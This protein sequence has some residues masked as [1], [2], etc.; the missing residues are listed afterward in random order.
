M[1]PLPF[2]QPTFV[3]S[4]LLLFL[5]FPA[6]SAPAADALCPRSA[7]T[8]KRVQRT[9]TEE[10]L[11]QL[12]PDGTRDAES[13][14]ISIDLTRTKNMLIPELKRRGL[15]PDE[16]LIEVD[17]GERL[18]PV[19][20]DRDR[21]TISGGPANRQTDFRVVFKRKHK[22]IH[23]TEARLFESLKYPVVAKEDYAAYPVPELSLPDD[24]V[25][26]SGIDPGLVR[27]SAQLQ[28]ENINWT[29][30]SKASPSL[31]KAFAEHG[32]ALKLSLSFGPDAVPTSIR[33]LDTVSKKEI[34]ADLDEIYITGG[35][36]FSWHFFDWDSEFVKR[37]LRFFDSWLPEK[38][39]QFKREVQL[40]TKT[41]AQPRELRANLSAYQRPMNIKLGETTPNREYYNPPLA[42]W[43]ERQ[44]VRWDPKKA[45]TTLPEMI[46]SLQQQRAWF[47]KN[48]SVCDE[49][50]KTLGFRWTNL[51]SGRDNAARELDNG[52][53]GVDLMSYYKMMLD[54]EREFH[55]MLGNWKAAEQLAKIADGIRTTLNER[56]WSEDLALYVDLIPSEQGNWKRDTNLSATGFWPAM[57]HVPDR[58]KLERMISE[59]LRNPKRFGSPFFPPSTSI[60][61]PHYDPSGDYWRGG[62]WPPDFIFFGDFLFENGLRKEASELL[63]KILATYTTVSR[64]YQKGESPQ[65]LI[66][67][68][69]SESEAAEMK[70]RGT[71]FEFYGLKKIDDRVAPTFGRKIREDGSYHQTRK[72]F[73]GWG[74]ATP[75]ESLRFIVG[76]DAVPAYAGPKKD[77]NRWIWTLLT[78]PQFNYHQIKAN[79]VLRP[80]AE[81]VAR[82]KSSFQGF[83]KLLKKAELAPVREELDK[84]GKG[85][86]EFSP[87]FNPEGQTELKHI[88]FDNT[89]ID[90]KV[91]RLESDR[92]IRLTVKSKERIRLQF[93]QNWSASGATDTPEASSSIVEIGSDRPVV[94]LTLA[95]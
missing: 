80:I 35:A 2:L 5:I 88:L 75:L 50:G 9:P 71:V 58:T 76:L 51:G 56:Y 66:Y 4:S 43:S 85:Y 82:P 38:M 11:H 81:Y 65:Q 18:I 72:N 36:A 70:R 95:R 46:L 89:W 45:S 74:S 61:N 55:L 22:E 23:V 49:N 39:R 93:N 34:P 33:V 91:E 83:E 57:A 21:L 6:Y 8:V 20:M 37:Y 44:V 60:D 78:D 16:I 40:K 12:V 30:T 25:R 54:Q 64:A 63:Q 73:A 92:H 77:I 79:P 1:R 29:L 3:A 27:L 48:H 24:F 67:G 47:L 62:G 7:A 13:G 10:A 31:K 19:S 94:E 84:L 87:T 59:N 15:T 42:G 14:E 52:G 68:K 53:L 41:G 28:R 32:S 86:L 26:K 17:G 90:L 69:S